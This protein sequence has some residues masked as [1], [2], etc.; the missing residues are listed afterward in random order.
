M[1][2]HGWIGFRISEDQKE[3]LEKIA[4]ESEMSVASIVRKAVDGVIRYVQKNGIKAIMPV[5]FDKAMK[6]KKRKKK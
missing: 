4:K 2:K 6:Q 3:A 1:K 5:D